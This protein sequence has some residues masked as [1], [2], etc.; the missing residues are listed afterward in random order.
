[1]VLALFGG[2]SLLLGGCHGHDSANI[3]LRKK[4]Q[5]LEAR[6]TDLQRRHDADGATIRGLQAGATTVPVLPQNELDELFTTAGL[7]FGRLT[8]GYRPDM[9]LPGDTMLKIYV[10]PIDEQGD[11]IKAAGSF[12]IELFDLALG[13]TN[14]I[15]QWD[16]DLQAA[17]A[18]WFDGGLL[19]TYVL[20]CPWQAAPE[21]AKLEM[22]LTFTDAL[23]HRVFIVDKDVTV[24]PP[25]K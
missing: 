6:I 5:L 22:R 13:A 23:T 17:R 19:Y 14:R 10:C 12:H 15:G 4:N 2:S 21:H 9:N 25:G 8:G 18:R 3:D 7:D 11:D 24:Q 1:M 20:D 16:F